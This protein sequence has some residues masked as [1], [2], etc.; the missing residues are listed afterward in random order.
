MVALLL[1]YKLLCVN[2]FVISLFLFYILIIMV[3]L[4]LRSL[5]VIESPL[6]IRAPQYIAFFFEHE[7]CT[8]V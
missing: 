1:Q 4:Y 2:S 3:Q 7:I 8:M 6:R 5:V